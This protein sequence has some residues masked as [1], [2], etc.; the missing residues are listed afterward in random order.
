M[1]PLFAP[2]WGMGGDKEP[3]SN[4]YEDKKARVV[5]AKPEKAKSTIQAWED[6][7]EKF[8]EQDSSSG[9]CAIQ[10]R[11]SRKFTHNPG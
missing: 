1:G 9:S 2:R 3:G 4:V 7:S 5:F 10:R 6:Q 11:C 8:S